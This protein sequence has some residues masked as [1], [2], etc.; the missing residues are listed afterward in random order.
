[1]EKYLVTIEFR[2]SDTPPEGYNYTLH[3][4]TVTI[5]VYDDF[6]DACKYGN[7]LMENLESKFQIHTLPDG[8]KAKKTDSVKMVGVLVVKMY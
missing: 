3:T 4:K 1:M 7:E 2:Y 6:D 8:T 5:G